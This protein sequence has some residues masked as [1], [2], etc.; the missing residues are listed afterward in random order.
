M[1]R[2]R[3]RGVA[4][5]DVPVLSEPCSEPAQIKTGVLYYSLTLPTFQTVVRDV[6]LCVLLREVLFYYAHRLLHTRTLYARIHKT[7]HRFTAPVAL[8]AQ[9]A[10]PLEHLA[11]NILPVALPPQIF[12]HNYEV[13]VCRDL[14]FGITLSDY[15]AARALPEG[16]IPRVLGLCIAEVDARGLNVEGIYRVR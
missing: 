15:A 14:T 3:W 5:V 4:L 9:Y 12:Y 13:G 8:A 11:A 1:L 16:Y 6:A 7:H 2:L 10:H